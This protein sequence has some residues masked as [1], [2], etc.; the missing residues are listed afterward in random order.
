M[1]KTCIDY[2]NTIIYKIACKDP[3]IKDIYI[4]HT[5]NF[6]QRK[7][8]HKQNCA[9]EKIQNEQNNLY[10]IIRENGGW[11]NWAMEIIKLFNC[12]DY[13]EA[14]AKEQ[15]YSI[16]FNATLNNIEQVIKPL[17]KCIPKIKEAYY[18]ERCNTSCNNSHLMD[19]H[20]QTIKHLKKCGETKCNTKVN[21]NPNNFICINCAFITSNQKDYSRHL[22]TRKHEKGVICN[23]MKQDSPQ[24]TPNM[25]HEC[26]C[27]KVLYNRTSIWRHNKICT[28]LQTDNNK[29]IILQL[30]QQH[31]EFKDLIL[32]QTNKIMELSQHNTMTNCHNNN[33]NN[34][35]NN[36]FNLNVFLNEKCKDAMNIGDFVNSL[37]LQIQ[38]L[39]NIGEYGFAEGI[40]RIFMRGLKELD[41]YKR[42]IHC[43]DL[44][45]E[46][47]HVKSENKWEKEGSERTQLKKAIKQIANKNICMI[48][49]WKKANPGC[50]KY[51]N[52][53]NDKYL[54]LMVESMGPADEKNEEKDFNKIIRF[55]A[56]ETVIDKECNYIL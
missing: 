9:N 54:K 1:P 27:G 23:K 25:Q 55:V 11:T 39:E 22:L 24:N 10:K 36:K 8:A 13:Y 19:K 51:N 50:E 2:S 26:I 28:A 45:R 34:T 49:E 37:Q 40:S 44:K 29:N 43:S 6:I 30:V 35:I 4:G 7:Y 32:E 31:Q 16:L 48:P 15:E 33:T 20:N 3:N 46:I 47:I 21:K 17:A 52:R 18:C 41:I 12:S 56:R 5:T 14:I 38:D 42:P 53:K